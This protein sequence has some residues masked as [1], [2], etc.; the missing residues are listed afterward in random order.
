MP[1]LSIYLLFLTI[2][3]CMLLIFYYFRNLHRVVRTEYKH[4]YWTK[5]SV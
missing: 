4:R 5:M 3:A 2:I 1:D